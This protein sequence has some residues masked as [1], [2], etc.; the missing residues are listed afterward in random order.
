MTGIP[1][2][3]LLEGEIEKL[4]HLEHKLSERVVGQDHVTN[5]VSDAVRLSRAGLQANN[6]PI[7][8]FLFLGS[9]GCG[10]SE[11]FKESRKTI[12]I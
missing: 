9:T 11:F 2:S 10:K 5:A 12:K 3:N 1:I 6:R 7:A 8:S 4:L